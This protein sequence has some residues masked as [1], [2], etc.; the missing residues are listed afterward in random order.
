MNIDVMRIGV[1]NMA[2]MKVGASLS[3][4]RCGLRGNFLLSQMKHLSSFER[5]HELFTALSFS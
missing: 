1:M 4:T 3:Y 2:V 5:L